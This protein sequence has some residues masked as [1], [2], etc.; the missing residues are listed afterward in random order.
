MPFSPLGGLHAGEALKKLNELAATCS[1]LQATLQQ[2]Q[3]QSEGHSQ[4][5][6]AVRQT[7]TQVLGLLER[8]LH[9]TPRS[10]PV[11]LVG[12]SLPS[13]L[14]LQA[15]VLQLSCGCTAYG[16][17]PWKAS[18]RSYNY[19]RAGFSFSRLNKQRCLPRCLQL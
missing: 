11:A 1:T 17:L 7:S 16:P 14:M 8:W 4:G 15:V 9:N 12:C 5:L 6:D 2:V 3:G 19:H 10:P 18:S 13:E